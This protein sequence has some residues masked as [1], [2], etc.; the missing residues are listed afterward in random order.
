MQDTYVVKVSVRELVES[1]LRSGDLGGGYVSGSRM[2]EGIRAHQTVS[3]ARGEECRPEVA[4]SYTVERDGIRLEVNGRIDGV[5]KRDSEVIIDEIKSVSVPIGEV[6]DNYSDLHWAQVKCYA[7]MFAVCGSLESVTVQVTY[8][9]IDTG[10]IRSFPK[11]FCRAELE[12]FFFDIAG[13]YIDWM[14]NVRDWSICRD[15][16]IKEMGFP[17]PSYRKGQ[18]ELAAAVYRAIKGGGRLFAQ[19]PTGTGKTMASL[20]PALKALGEGH[21]SKIFYLTAKTTT[22][23]V[24]QKALDS[25]RQSGLKIKSIVITAKEKVCFNPGAKCTGE[26]CRYARGYYDRLNKAIGDIYTRNTFT[27]DLIEEYAQRHEVCPFEFSLDLSLWADG[28]ICDYNYVFDPRV[29]LKRY[30]MSGGGD[31]AFLIDEAHNL[32]DRAREM[33]SAQLLKAPVTELK[34]SMGRSRTKLY[35]SLNEINSYMIKKRKECEGLDDGVYLSS[36]PLKDFY[37]V[38]RSF[39]RYADEFLAENEAS[40]FRE[41]LLEV[42][43]SVIDFLKTSEIYDERYVTYCHKQGNDFSIRLFCID[44]SYLLYE[45][46]KRGK[47][48]I[49]FS[50]TLIPLRYFT[51]ILGGDPEMTARDNIGVSKIA[52]SSPFPKENLC[53]MVDYKTATRYSAREYTY[54]RIVNAISAVAGSRTGNYIV[55][56]PSYKYML[57]IHARFSSIG[58]DIKIICQSPGMM[59][60]DREE[61]LSQFDESPGQTLVGFAVMGGVFGEG[62]DLVGERLSG[63]VVVGVG[64]PQVCLEREIIRGYFEQNGE[65]GFDYAYVYPGMNKVMQAAGRVIRTENDRGAVLLID[66]RFTRSTYRELMPPHWDPV[67]RVDGPDMMSMRL[68][69]FWR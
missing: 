24:A 33:F 68:E 4:V 14:K 66:E 28:I 15:A 9:Q 21:V 34:K 26:E 38:L 51:R 29:Y 30:F 20:F 11:A 23:A 36:E 40:V 6:N 59:E 42:Y 41:Q 22:R 17:F 53:L 57:E 65:P 7:Y 1:L 54:D 12:T 25:M 39:A 43:F 44:P 49:L 58:A 64:L 35:K 45:A 2:L 48:S 3:K 61:F 46:M 10:E 60:E 5:I 56:F 50:A 69:R 8:F 47:A 62:I 13:R 16:S 19:A 63:V 55:F 37:P 27:R 32:V 31:Y 18:R 52:L 67:V